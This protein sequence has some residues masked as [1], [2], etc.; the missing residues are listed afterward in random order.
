MRRLFN[1]GHVPTRIDCGKLN[2][3]ANCI[4][5]FNRVELTVLATAIRWPL[6]IQSARYWKLKC[7]KLVS[8]EGGSGNVSLQIDNS[9]S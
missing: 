6:L 3:T 1:L 4:V 5:V 2:E 9:F 8:K 7:Q